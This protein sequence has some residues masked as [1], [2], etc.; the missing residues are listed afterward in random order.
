M[1]PFAALAMFW[2]GGLSGLFGA[3]QDFCFGPVDATGICG[4]GASGTTGASAGGVGLCPAH[5]QTLAAIVATA[6]TAITTAV[7]ATFRARKGL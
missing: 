4:V 5:T 1:G 2:A 3:G 6:E 7:R